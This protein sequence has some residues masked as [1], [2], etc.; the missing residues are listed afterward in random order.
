M[1]KRY[2]RYETPDDIDL[3]NP[4]R[5]PRTPPFTLAD[6]ERVYLG[7]IVTSHFPYNGKKITTGP[8]VVVGVSGPCCCPEYLDSINA[9]GWTDPNKPDFP[10]R[11][12]WHVHLTCRNADTLGKPRKG[13]ES[14]L[15]QIKL[16]G[17]GLNG[18]REIRFHQAAHV[19]LFTGIPG[20]LGGGYRHEMTKQERIADERERYLKA[21]GRWKAPKKNP[22]KKTASGKSCSSIKKVVASKRSKSDKGGHETTT[23]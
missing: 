4:K 7:K 6:A 3:P 19:D 21:M 17:T 23:P 16:D 10:K 5:Y 1:S 11:T 15:N 9:R 12:D 14:Y 20:E 8:Y 18:R 22:K 2:K 13:N